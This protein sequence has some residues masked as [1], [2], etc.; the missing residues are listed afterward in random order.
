M[1]MV[2]LT[3]QSRCLIRYGYENVNVTVIAKLFKRKYSEISVSSIQDC[4]DYLN[5]CKNNEIDLNSAVFRGTLYELFS[6]K[7]LQNHLNGRNLIKVGGAY[8]NGIDILGKWD[9]Q[10]FYDK[11]SQSEKDKLIKIPSTSL[12]KQSNVFDGSISLKNDITILVQC[13]NSVQK[14]TAKIIRE[15]SGIYHYHIG[16]QKNLKRAIATH[17]LFLASPT[18]L[19]PQAIKQLDQS[20]I[21]IIHMRLDPLVLN[22]V[23]ADTDRYLLQ[24]WNEGGKLHSVYLNIMARKLLSGF[25]LE[26]QLQALIHQQSLLN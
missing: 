19:T 15:L 14:M 17:Y 4:Q 12:L 20:P 7:V 1:S 25:K 22:Q 6:L 2:R 24:N 18:R 9:L 10:A 23:D 13:K 5:Y 21:P 11:V 8:D 26:L 16:S 3:S